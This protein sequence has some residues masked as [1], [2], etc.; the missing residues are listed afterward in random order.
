M[1]FRIIQFILSLPNGF[2]F[3][4]RSIEHSAALRVTPRTPRLLSFS[5]HFAKLF[6]FNAEFAEFAEF[7]EYRCDHTALMSRIIFRQF[8]N[9]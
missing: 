6:R 3:R 2:A 4:P 9:L 1:S 5:C 8:M 7:A